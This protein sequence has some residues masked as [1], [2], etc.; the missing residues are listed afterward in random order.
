MGSQVKPCP[1]AH[2]LRVAASEGF[3]I[4]QSYRETRELLHAAETGCT[5]SAR[6]VLE[7]TKRSCWR[8]SCNQVGDSAL[9]LAARAGHLDVVS[10]LLEAKTNLDFQNAKGEVALHAACTE[11]YLSVVEKLCAASADPFLGDL[12]G[13]EVPALW[14]V[15][16]RA[17]W[18]KNGGSLSAA[19]AA[20]VVDVPWLAP[21]PQYLERRLV[22]LDTI[23]EAMR[24]A[25]PSAPAAASL[26]NNSR[27]TGLH[28]AVEAAD[29]EVCALLLR[30]DAPVEAQEL[31]EG[32][33]PLM[34]ACAVAGH[35]VGEA[36]PAATVL[37]LLEAAADPQRKDLRGG[38]ALH[39][40]A[41]AGDPAVRAV[42]LLLQAQAN[43]DEVDERGAS[44]LAVAALAGATTVVRRL[45]AAGAKPQTCREVLD[46]MPADGPRSND[47]RTCRQIL[48]SVM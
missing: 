17:E 12:A 46:M 7:G 43:P 45:L 41:A 10:L 25:D 21:T 28:I 39:Y 32:A 5:V 20:G 27:L 33:T 16:R 34:Q 42:E 3:A 2:V 48:E 37:L 29:A 6:R 18:M 36:V 30:Y 14:A 38:L 9:H 23:L 22:C 4:T 8:G 26:L 1:S 44:C 24:L 13:N 31:E 47:G 15:R 35:A 11:P 19:G 40:A